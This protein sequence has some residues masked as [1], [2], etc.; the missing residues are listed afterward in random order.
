VDAAISEMK[1]AMVLII[2]TAMLSM[3]V[4]AFLRG[5]RQ[6]PRIDLGPTRLSA[7]ANELRLETR[8][9]AWTA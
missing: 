4:D 2:A 6:R 7:G 9:L 5:L 3:A 1:L 8:G